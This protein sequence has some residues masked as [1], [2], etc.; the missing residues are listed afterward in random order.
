MPDQIDRAGEGEPPNP[1]D[2]PPPAAEPPEPRVPPEKVPIVVPKKVQPRKGPKDIKG[3][4]GFVKKGK[5]L[6][7]I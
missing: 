2:P 1:A 4:V 3:Y 6:E 7:P 5:G